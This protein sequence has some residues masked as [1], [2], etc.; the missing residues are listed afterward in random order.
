MDFNH[1]EA[2]TQGNQLYAFLE[3]VFE[4]KLLAGTTRRQAARMRIL[5]DVG[6]VTL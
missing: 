1:P 2:I 6:D 4:A 5:E 3:Q